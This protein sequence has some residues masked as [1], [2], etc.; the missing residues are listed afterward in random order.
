MCICTTVDMQAHNSCCAVQGIN[1]P[2]D[3]YYIFWQLLLY[4]PITSI[5]LSCCYSYIFQSHLL[6]LSITSP[7]SF[8]HISYIFQWLLILVTIVRSDDIC[9]TS[10]TYDTC[11]LKLSSRGR[12]GK[13]FQ[14]S[15][16]PA[17]VREI[18]RKPCHQCHPSFLS[19]L[20][21]YSN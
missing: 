1:N 13:I 9:D 5:I 21:S 8:N 19:K 6:Y 12:A 14:K 16:P 10:D 3:R 4:L 2:E 11:F 15:F 7:I 20:L 17:Y 18:L